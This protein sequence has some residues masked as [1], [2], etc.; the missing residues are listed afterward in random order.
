MNIEDI[1]KDAIKEA[2]TAQMAEQA[3]QNNEPVEE[4][5]IEVEE[6]SATALE[7]NAKSGV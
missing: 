7:S 3:T 2:V 4:E 6:A 5:E 1:I